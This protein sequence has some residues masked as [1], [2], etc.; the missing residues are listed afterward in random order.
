MSTNPARPRRPRRHRLLAFSAAA[1]LGALGQPGDADGEWREEDDGTRVLRRALVLESVS[2]AGRQPIPRDPVAADVAAGTFTPPSEGDTVQPVTGGDPREWHWREAD[3]E[4]AIAGEDLAGAYVHVSLE[5]DEPAVMLLDAAG[6]NIAYV[7]GSP[8]AGDTY[9]N[10]TL[11]LPIELEAG[12]NHLLLQVGRGRLT[13]RLQPVES[14]ISF[15]RRDD[16][17][18]DARQGDPINSPV[19][20][21]I[22]NASNEWRRDLTVRLRGRGL[23]QQTTDLPPLP[24]M[25]VRKLPVNVEGPPPESTDALRAELDLRDPAG[26]VRDRRELTLQV[27]RPDE[28]HRRTF[29]SRIDHSVQYYAVLPAAASDD[30]PSPGLVLSL[31]GASVEALSQVQAYSPKE[32]LHIVAPTNR[33]PFGFDWEDWGRRDAMEVLDRAEATL[34]TEPRRTYLTGHSMGG[35][36]AWHLAVTYPDRFAA[37]APSAGWVSMFSYAGADRTFDADSP[38]A[39]SLRRAMNP[40]DTLALRHNLRPLGVYILHGSNDTNVRPAEAR[41]MR[42]RLGEFHNDFS[43]YE[44]DGAGHWWDGPRAAGVD[45]VD[46]PPIFQFFRFREK[47]HDPDVRRLT[48]ATA[49]P[50]VSARMRWA[51]VHTQQHP[52]DIS[53]IDLRHEPSADAPAD[54][55]EDAPAPGSILTGAT[56]NVA[57]LQ[58][59]TAPFTSPLDVTLDGDTFTVAFAEDDTALYFARDEQGRWRDTDRPPLNH[60]HPDRAGPFKAA[61]DDGM[62]FVYGTQGSDAENAWAYNKARLDAQAFYYRGNGDVPLIADTDYDADDWPDQSVIVYGHAESNAAWES[63]LGDSPLQVGPG[64]IELGDRAFKGD[65][66]AALLVRPHP[67]SDTAHVAAVTGTAAHGMRLTHRLPYFVSGVA[68]PDY[69][70]FRSD[71]LLDGLSGVEAA[72]FFDTDW[73]LTTNPARPR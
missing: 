55:D 45:C 48:F 10:R 33:R 46:W 37:V 18:F 51:T 12:E 59:D 64:R 32:D 56:S 23:A 5:L 66:L 9:H 26:R 22:I 43:Y 4:G 63:L 52:R 50:G 15:S 13:L 62:V 73:S 40:S 72:G 21:V 16:T 58:L 53:R 44:Q 8:L 2:S 6:H 54:A 7:N 71:A 24:P 68:Y 36:G 70:I 30:A 17:L 47:P 41:K 65:D 49:D 28:P 1:L 19:G 35:H 11:L 39:E 25:T 29:I 3:E 31:H 14:P 69:F 34:Q 20:V 61:F 57:V 42:S 38:L 27:R 60:K 67:E